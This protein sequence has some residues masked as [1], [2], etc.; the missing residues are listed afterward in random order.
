MIKFRDD[1]PYIWYVDSNLNLKEQA[2]K[3]DQP[4]HAKW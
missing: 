1:E 3:A 2:K 4:T